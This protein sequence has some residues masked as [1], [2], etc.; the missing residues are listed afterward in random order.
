MNQST[1]ATVRQGTAVFATNKLIRNTYILL[2]LTLLFS[3]ATAGISMVA[4]IPHPGLVITLVG[5]FGLLFLVQA[6]RNSVW[7]IVSVLSLIHI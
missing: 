3:A 5:Y 7:G 6:L 1:N 4:N 2:S